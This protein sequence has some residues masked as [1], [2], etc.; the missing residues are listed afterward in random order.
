MNILQIQSRNSCSQCCEHFANP[1][2][3][4][5]EHFAIPVKFTALWTFCKSSQGTVVH[6]IVSIL[7]IQSRN[8][9][10]QHCGHFANSV[11]EQLFIALW[12]FC[13]SS[14]ETVVHSIVDI[15]Q[16]QSRNSCSTLFNLW[17]ECHEDSHVWGTS[18]QQFAREILSFKHA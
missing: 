17:W 11:K 14:Q 16:I 6:S 5:C 7:Q 8:S 2:K 1:V 4:Q 15:L 18:S 13:K 12:T 9:C 10:S 3:E